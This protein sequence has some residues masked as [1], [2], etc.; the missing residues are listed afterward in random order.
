MEQNELSEIKQELRH[1]VESMIRLEEKFE[2]HK[3]ATELWQRKEESYTKNYI[4]DI[5]KIQSVIEET[6][7]EV[8]INSSFRK[9]GIRHFW[10]LWVSATG[11]VI[12]GLVRFFFFKQ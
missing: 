10:I 8:R 7:K 3:A 11:A 5:K 1:L 12:G 2:A 9:L 4:Q 6:T